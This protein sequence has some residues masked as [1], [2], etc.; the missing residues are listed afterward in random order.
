MDSFHAPTIDMTPLHVQVRRYLCW[1]M[2]PQAFEEIVSAAGFST[3]YF[4]TT[5]PPHPA[6]LAALIEKASLRVGFTPRGFEAEVRHWSRVAADLPR[7]RP[8]SHRGG[9]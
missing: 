4:A 1:L 5:C 7:P 9:A 8:A 3:G 6:D 2:G